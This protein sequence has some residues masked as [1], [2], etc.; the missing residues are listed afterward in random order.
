MNPWYFTLIAILLTTAAV[1]VALRWRKGWWVLV[2]LGVG[3]VAASWVF[4]NDIPRRWH[5]YSYA[6][7][8]PWVGFPLLQFDSLSRIV[9]GGLIIATMTVTIHSGWMEFLGPALARWEL[10][11]LKTEF[12]ANG[13]CRQST[14]YTCGPA[15]AVTAL[16]KLGVS[17]GEGELALLACTGPENGTDPTDLAAAIRE[18]FGGAGIR[19][20]DHALDTLADLEKAGLALTVIKWDA[21][22]DHWVTMV[23]MNEREVRYADPVR[24]LRTVPRAE[25]QSIWEHETVRIWKE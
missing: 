15:A 20:D 19:V 23:E 3:T 11:K 13:I 10:A 18:R 4:A 6:L 16:R 5:G 21:T 24:G 17:A 22:E 12:D 14:D 9:K 1:V 2:A 25:F 8:L 7:A